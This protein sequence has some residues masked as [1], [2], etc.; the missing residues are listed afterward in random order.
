[1]HSQQYFTWATILP[2]CRDSGL[3]YDIALDPLHPLTVHEYLQLRVNF[4]DNSLIQHL[5]HFS[6]SSLTIVR[7][8]P[9]MNDEKFHFAVNIWNGT[10]PYCLYSPVLYRTVWYCTTDQRFV[11]S[12]NFRPNYRDKHYNLFVWRAAAYK[13]SEELPIT[14]KQF[15]WSNCMVV[16]FI[17]SSL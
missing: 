13:S 10:V 5:N 17:N 8:K 11:S 16:R 2:T 1:M 9:T 7:A 4:T 3:Y 6:A 15:S 14:I 12:E